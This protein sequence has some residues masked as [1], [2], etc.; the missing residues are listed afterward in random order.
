MMTSF[1]IRVMRMS[2]RTSLQRKP[3]AFELFFCWANI[4]KYHKCM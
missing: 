4:Q 3:C 2:G 1:R